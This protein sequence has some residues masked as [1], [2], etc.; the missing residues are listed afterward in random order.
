MKNP[1]K[2]VGD[3]VEVIVDSKT[4]GIHVVLLDLEDLPRF[5]GKTISIRKGTGKEKYY[6][7]VRH[8]GKP[9][10][11]HRF[12]MDYDGPLLV[13]HRDGNGL[14]D[15]KENLRLAT[16]SQNAQNIESNAASQSGIKGLVY[17]PSKKKWRVRIKLEGKVVFE[18][19]YKNKEKAIEVLDRKLEKYHGEFRRKTD[20]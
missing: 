2:I 4:H 5:E 18:H 16:V 8:N 1:H 3:T 11:L 7:V 17:D 19:F 6:G 15:K 12:V 13:D 9:L 14:N 10:L 20:G